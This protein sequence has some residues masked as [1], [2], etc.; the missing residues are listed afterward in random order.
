M[1]NS[2]EIMWV[3]IRFDP[4][5]PALGNAEMEDKHHGAITQYIARL[6]A[7]GQGE[8]FPHYRILTNNASIAEI[9]SEKDGLILDIFRAPDGKRIGFGL[10]VD[11]AHEGNASLVEVYQWLS[12]DVG[13]SGRFVAVFLWSPDSPEKQ[14]RA[15]VS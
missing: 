6:T 9:H 8:V 13:V 10:Q 3:G 2:R 1:Y 12:E 11:D 7:S 14:P 4:D 5:H 15:L